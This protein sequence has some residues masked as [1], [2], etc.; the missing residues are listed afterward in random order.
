[1]ATNAPILGGTPYRFN[2]NG[3]QSA[4]GNLV[5]S[6]KY[7]GGSNGGSPSMSNLM[8][9][10]SSFVPKDGS[11]P[12]LP[13]VNILNRSADRS[14]IQQMSSSEKQ[15]PAPASRNTAYSSHQV[16]LNTSTA[17]PGE[18]GSLSDLYEIEKINERV[19]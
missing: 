17:A 2:D 14:N 10:E 19:A 5:S 12:V 3:A 7:R 15:H 8:R 16:T 11:V 6:A 9:V 1:M 13:P 4:Y 18:A